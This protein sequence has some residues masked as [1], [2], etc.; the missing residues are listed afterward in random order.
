MDFVVRT[1]A[2]PRPGETV[3]GSGFT[4]AHGGKGANLAVAAARAGGDVVLYAAVGTDS[5]GNAAL[6]VL[7]REGIDL[8]GAAR[9]TDATG[10]AVILV[11]DTGEN[12]IVV[13][14]G[15]NARAEGRG[16]AWQPGDVAAAVLEVPI[17]A[18]EDF[19][20][21]A[22]AGG[23]TTFLNAAP[24]T[25]DA[26][27]LVGLCDVVCVNE[28]ELTALGGSVGTAALVVTL[29]SRGLRVVDGDGEFSAPGHTVEVVDTVGAGDAMCGVLVAE[30]ARGRSLRDAAVRANAAGA[31]T[32]RAAGARTSPTRAE[33]DA[34][35]AGCS[36]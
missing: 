27:R 35:L 8:A 13:V 20:T 2:L 36:R 29:G 26:A 10:I 25:P 11:D 1:S 15:A 18:V 16:A 24:A 28:H 9:V 34:F 12:E 4:Q 31:L 7:A 33:V 23:A 30:L 6:D 5:F 17:D 19:F 14:A 3:S 22:R 21:A 32:V